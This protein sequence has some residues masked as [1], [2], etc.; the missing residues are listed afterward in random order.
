MEINI[1]KQKVNNI[2]RSVLLMHSDTGAHPAEL[3]LAFS[4]CVGRII[5]TLPGNDLVKKDLLDL[6]IKHMAAT[7]HAGMDRVI[8]M[9]N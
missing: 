6:S 4:E 1:D 3:V 5:T 8:E 9:P 7:I 2:V